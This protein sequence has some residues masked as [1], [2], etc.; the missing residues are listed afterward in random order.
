M[1]VQHSHVRSTLACMHIVLEPLLS[2][3]FLLS[4]TPVPLLVAIL[5][6]VFLLVSSYHLTTTSLSNLLN[7]RPYSLSTALSLRACISHLKMHPWL[8]TAELR[9][10]FHLSRLLQNVVMHT[11]VTTLRNY[12]YHTYGKLTI[13]AH[14]KIN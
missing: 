4:P 6:H 10:I 13:I 14:Y 7:Q 5:P 8:V 3:P 12:K 11:K 2:S 9:H 1:N